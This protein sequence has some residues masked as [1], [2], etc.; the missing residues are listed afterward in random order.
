MTIAAAGD[1]V[2]DA[3]KG[4]RAI[5][6]FNV[7][8]LEHAEAIVAAAESVGRPVILAVSENC[9]RFHLGRVEPL[10]DA[11]A[12]IGRAASV[13]VGLH[14]DHVTDDDL[15]ANAKRAGFMS[16]MYDAAALPYAQNVA[17]TQAATARAHAQGL[18][19]EAELGYV[20]GKG[21][22]V[23]SAHSPGVRTDPDE[24][25]AFLT[26]TSVDAL[27]IAVGS[28]HAMTSRTA[29][30]DVALIATLR[31]RLPVPLVLHGCSGVPDDGLRAAVA[32]GITKVNVGTALG[33]AM[34]ASIRAALHADPD[35]VDPRSYLVPARDAM[36]ATARH[37]LEVLAS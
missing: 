10:T 31:R 9:A 36:T 7:I 8:T 29:R 2:I 35:L 12:A 27:A 18:W 22:V 20:G 33:Q 25:H 6:A 30:L 14:L 24:A 23:Q 21:G 26:A 32:A 11:C 13:P 3:W 15:A 19:I 1:L 17:R 4:S 28:S 37:L 34:T 5:A 16:L